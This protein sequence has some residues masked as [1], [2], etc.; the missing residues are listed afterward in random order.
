MFVLLLD[1][2]RSNI[3]QGPGPEGNSFQ[4]ELQAGGTTRDTFVELELQIDRLQQRVRTDILIH[5][6]GC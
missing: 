3:G 1:F 4:T 2:L 5:D 6:Q